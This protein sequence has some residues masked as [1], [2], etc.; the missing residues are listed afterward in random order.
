M[1][2]KFQV[3][4]HDSTLNEREIKRFSSLLIINPWYYIN[5]KGY[6]MCGYEEVKPN[7]HQLIIKISN[8]LGAT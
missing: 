3:S 7:K 8:L 4:S 6:R 1:K 2:K 5:V